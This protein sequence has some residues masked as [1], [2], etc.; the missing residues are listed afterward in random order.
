ML[1]FHVRPKRPSL[2]L[3]Q[4]NNRNKI[5]LYT[6]RKKKKK[7]E[8]QKID[9]LEDRFLLQ[10]NK[11]Y[12][13]A[14]RCTLFR[15]AHFF[16]RGS[17]RFPLL[18]L[19]SMCPRIN[20]ILDRRYIRLFLYPRAG[21]NEPRD[22]LSTQ[23]RAFLRHAVPFYSIYSETQSFRPSREFRYLQSLR[24]REPRIRGWRWIMH[25]F[26]TSIRDGSLSAFT[27]PPSNHR[28]LIVF[29]YATVPRPYS[30]SKRS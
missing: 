27:L 17:K 29:R 19:W 28:P 2:Q 4:P 26:A 3:F 21:I 23:T 15:I 25:P 20:R 22:R 9:D 12:S 10:I 8:S 7:I 5:N 6:K 30:H 11:I 13:F 14:S 16:N 18:L 24:S 1:V